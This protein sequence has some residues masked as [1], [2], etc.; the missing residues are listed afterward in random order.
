MAPLLALESRNDVGQTRTCGLCLYHCNRG[1]IDSALT[2]LIWLS[3]F[4]RKTDAK[5]AP[6]EQSRCAVR[7]YIHVVKTYLRRRAKRPKP[8]S[9]KMI[10]EDGSGTALS[11]PGV[12]VPTMYVVPPSGIA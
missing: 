10:A 3:M 7:M 11:K 6:A 1:L 9:P 2:F 5:E 8:A 4:A 12:G